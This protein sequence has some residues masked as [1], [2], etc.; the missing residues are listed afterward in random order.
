MIKV[1]VLLFALILVSSFKQKDV[2]WVAIGDSITYLN[3]HPDETGNRVKK[4]YLTRVTD[5]LPNIKYINQGHNG[6]TSG[7]IADKIDSLGLIKADVYSVFLGTNDWW[8]GRPVGTLN[9]YVKATGN[10]TINGSFRIIINKIKSLNPE[11]KIVLI[12]PMQRT[13]F[14]Y[15]FDANNNAY[16]SYKQKNGQSLESVANAIDSIAHYQHIPVVDL[17][18][19]SA[20]S[21]DQMV[22][23]KRLKNPATGKYQNY[24]YPEYT[25]IPFDPKADE[26]PNP[27]DAVNITYD[28]LHPSDK[29]NAIIAEGIVKAFKKLSI[30]NY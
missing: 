2:T 17:Y 29:G 23:F 3:D 28:G 24:S 16:G 19:N 15:L 26:Y 14:V 12:T 6:W 25:T 5:A 8:Q 1:V 11:A 22:N 9:D 20:L 7:G 13:D 4:G 10:A 27:M 18:H 30:G 21:V